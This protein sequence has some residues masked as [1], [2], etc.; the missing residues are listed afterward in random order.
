MNCPFTNSPEA[1]ITTRGDYVWFRLGGGRSYA[2]SN[3]AIAM[4]K[5]PANAAL[6]QKQSASLRST[7]KNFK[8]P[9]FPMIVTTA[10]RTYPLFRV[11]TK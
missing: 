1:G 5:D 2:V 7:I 6:V 3:S 10:R 9:G 11:D 8:G 4:A